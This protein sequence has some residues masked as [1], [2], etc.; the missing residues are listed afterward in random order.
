MRAVDEIYRRPLDRTTDRT[1]DRTGAD[2]RLRVRRRVFGTMTAVA[3]SVYLYLWL[4]GITLVAW[5]VGL[6]T[7]WVQAVLQR[8]SVDVAEMWL[9][10]ALVVLLGCALVLWAERQRQRFT[11]VERRLRA[12]DATPAEVA[13]SL[14]AAPVVLEA[15]QQG[16]VVTAHHDADGRVVRV[17]TGVAPGAA[18]APWVPVQ[19]TPAERAD[20]T[21]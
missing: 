3:W 20:L 4:P 21:V 15:L 11:G 13:V 16:Q 19:R 7:A 9:G 1:T 12:P 10:L 14:G 2:D 6:R 17:V 18:Q 8:A 5:L